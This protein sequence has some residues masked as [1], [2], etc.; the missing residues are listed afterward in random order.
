MEE[1]SLSICNSEKIAK[2]GSTQSNESLNQVISSKNPKSRHYAES[3]SLNFRVSAA[4][5]QKNLG[6]QYSPK[7]FEKLG[8]QQSE[9]SK[10][11][12]R[13]EDALRQTKSERSKEIPKKTG[14]GIEKITLHKKCLLQ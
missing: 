3:E 11:T 1:V 2:C 13:K 9:K 8:Y 12:K 14:A 10:T 6:V 4:I 5:C 7:A